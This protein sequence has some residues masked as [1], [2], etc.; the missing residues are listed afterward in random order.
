MLVSGE[1]IKLRQFLLMFPDQLILRPCAPPS[2]TKP[3]EWRKQKGVSNDVRE[4]V[5]WISYHQPLTNLRHDVW[6]IQNTDGRQ[7]RRRRAYAIY[8]MDVKRRR[9]FSSPL[10]GLLFVNVVLLLLFL[11]LFFS[12]MQETKAG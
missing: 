11:F 4:A 9:R 2:D 3:T 1:P 6:M 10:L 7:H 12:L 8:Y 5:P